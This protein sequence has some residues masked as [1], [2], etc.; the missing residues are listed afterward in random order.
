M[1]LPKPSIMRIK[2]KG[3]RGSP[4]LRPLEGMKISEGDP[5]TRIKT[6][7]DVTKAITYLTQL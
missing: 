1:A 5:F 4:C 6:M 7:E 2:R 3:E